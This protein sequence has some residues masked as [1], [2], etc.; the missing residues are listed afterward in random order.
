MTLCDFSNS[1]AENEKNQGFSFGITEYW[2]YDIEQ[3]SEH[4]A[5]DKHGN[6]RCKS[7]CCSPLPTLRGLSHPQ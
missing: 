6:Y 7:C 1:G 5:Y 3:Y 2:E 4:R